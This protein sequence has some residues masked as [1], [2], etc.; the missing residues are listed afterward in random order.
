MHAQHACA[1]TSTLSPKIKVHGLAHAQRD[2]GEDFE[3]TEKSSLLGN[4]C[5]GQMGEPLPILPRTPG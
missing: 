2:F 1:T 4:K 3:V 5:K